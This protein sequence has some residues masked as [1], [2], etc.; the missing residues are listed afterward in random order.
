M[1]LVL[2]AISG[3][4]SVPENAAA[5]VNGVVISKDDV[6]HR[7]QVG[8]AINPGKVPTDPNSDEYKSFQRDITRQLIGE[9]LERQEAEKRG[10]SVSADEITAVVDQVVENKYFGSLQKLQEDYARRGISEEELRLQIYRTILHRKLYESLRAEVAPS[11][12]EI[13][14]QYDANIDKFIYPEKRQVR[15]IIVKSEAAAKTIEGRINAGE[16]MATIAKSE[17]TDAQ[18]KANGGY[19]GVVTQAD[20]P[21]E[22]GSVTFSLAKGQ[23]S[24]PIMSAQGWYIVRVELII[25]ASNRTWDQVKDEQMLYASNQRLA[26]RYK[27]YQQEVYDSYDIQYAD[28]YAPREKSPV[29]TETPVSTVP[30]V[31]P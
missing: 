5:T 1:A 17:S 23:V 25:P 28:D 26:D 10:V 16:D 14:A 3:C 21:P 30:E 6:A 15:Q 12:E 19:L 7:I 8:A 24:D 29:T 27:Q 13:K 2:F 4:S 20:M 22:V 11:E 18:T 31:Q 9:E